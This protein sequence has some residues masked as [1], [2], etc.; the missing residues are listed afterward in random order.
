MSH[1]KTHASQRHGRASSSTRH[2]VTADTNSTSL[3]PVHQRPQRPRQAA[4]AGV[5]LTGR[6]LLSSNPRAQSR[7][8]IPPPWYNR[9]ASGSVRRLSVIPDQSEPSSPLSPVSQR[10]QRRSSASPLP[11]HRNDQV[12][13][14]PD[15]RL[16]SQP[17]PNPFDTPQGR[18]RGSHAGRYVKP[19]PSFVPDPDSASSSVPPSVPPKDERPS[20]YVTKKVRASDLEA[21]FGLGEYGAAAAHQR[22]TFPGKILA[23]PLQRAGESQQHAEWDSE[24]STPTASLNDY[25]TATTSSTAA[26]DTQL[27]PIQLVKPITAAERSGREAVGVNESSRSG[28]PTAVAPLP[29][30]AATA[31]FIQQTSAEGDRG[32]L[33]MHTVRLPNGRTIPTVRNDF[34]N[35]RRISV[36]KTSLPSD[37]AAQGPSDAAKANAAAQETIPGSHT[38]PRKAVPSHDSPSNQSEERRKEGPQPATER[39]R[40]HASQA[41]PLPASPHRLRPLMLSGDRTVSNDRASQM[42]SSPPQHSVHRS[43]PSLR[44]SRLV[45]A[46]EAG[47]TRQT[48]GPG[49]SLFEQ[50]SA[51]I[52]SNRVHDS[53]CTEVE[54]A[55]QG[56]AS[57][58]RPDEMRSPPSDALTE[59]Q[60]YALEARNR[61]A[62]S[63]LPFVANGSVTKAAAPSVNYRRPSISSEKTAIDEDGAGNK[64][65]ESIDGSLKKTNSRRRSSST[66]LGR[67]HRPFAS[68]LVAPPS[69]VQEASEPGTVVKERQGTEKVQENQPIPI[70]NRPPPGVTFPPA[71]LARP[72]T[73]GRPGTSGTLRSLMSFRSRTAHQRDGDICPHCFRAGFDCAL[74]LNIN[75][76]TAGRKTFQQ[77]VAGVLPDVEHSARAGRITPL[78]TSR[79]GTR[80][81]SRPVTRGSAA[82]GNF[83]H[84][85]SV[86]F[87]E[88]ALSR[89]V[90][91]GAVE[92]L[93]AERERTHVGLNE[94]LPYEDFMNRLQQIQ[95]QQ[96]DEKHHP[97]RSQWSISP[98]NRTIELDE[99]LGEGGERSPSGT[100]TPVPGS[101]PWRDPHQQH[102]HVM[103]SNMN[104]GCEVL[105]RNTGFSA[106]TAQSDLGDASIRSEGKF[107]MRTG[108]TFGFFGVLL[109]CVQILNSGLSG[110]MTGQTLDKPPNSTSAM[111]GRLAF[112]WGEV[113]GVFLG[114]CLYRFGTW[115]LVGNITLAGVFALVAGFSQTYWA[116]NVLRG[117]IGLCGGVIF[118]FSIGNLLDMLPSAHLRF[119][120]LLTLI[121]LVTVPQLV[122]PWV[123]QLFQIYINWRWLYWAAAIATACAVPILMLLAREPWINRVG[124]PNAVHDGRHGP[125]QGV[126]IFILPIS[127]LC[128]HPHLLLCSIPMAFALGILAMLLINIHS[129]WV[130]AYNFS[131]NQA[132]LTTTICSLLGLIAAIAWALITAAWRQDKPKRRL[133]LDE[134]GYIRVTPAKR[135]EQRLFKVAGGMLI[136]AIALFLL[137]ITTRSDMVHW[138]ASALLFAIMAG[139]III[140]AIGALQYPI[141]VYHPASALII[142]TSFD[143]LPNLQML[144]EE[145]HWGRQFTLS[146][147]AGMA[148][149]TLAT[150]GIMSFIA[151]DALRGVGFST[152]CV[153][154]A[155]CALFAG[156]ATVLLLRLGSVMRSNAWQRHNSSMRRAEEWRCNDRRQR[157]EE[158]L[159]LRDADVSP[160]HMQRQP[161]DPHATARQSVRDHPTLGTTAG[162][163]IG[164]SRAGPAQGRHST[165]KVPKRPP[166]FVLQPPRESDEIG[167]ARPHTPPGSFTSRLT[168]GTRPDSRINDVRR[169]LVRGRSHIS[170]MSERYPILPQISPT[171]RPALAGVNQSAASNHPVDPA[172]REA[173]MNTGSRLKNQA[174]DT[175]VDARI[176]SSIRVPQ[177]AATGHGPRY[178]SGTRRV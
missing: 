24:E 45:A 154:L 10:S 74:N 150:V 11:H 69:A 61:I 1:Y 123:A 125:G 50:A 160:S 55:V 43:P 132:A 131:D 87:G 84:L 112:F 26:R 171:D 142:A 89:P 105:R 58:H 9:D 102:Y 78:I 143:D 147:V 111:G 3:E 64:V 177:V 133:H 40:T 42:P 36:P 49:A 136:S 22:Q 134:N 30:A 115:I 65:K 63:G 80:G 174:N 7:Q 124:T 16:E 175:R 34:A 85:G 27:I 173:V 153:I 70:I 106:R 44:S 156:G 91:R 96:Q 79:P 97:E 170:H 107:T 93:L 54:T 158:G 19:A 75:G 103:Y 48:F 81:S 145:Q 56:N 53:Q 77:F 32:E 57:P 98:T 15:S 86:A 163:D 95:E 114:A 20:T 162:K 60:S 128:V 169:F 28:P 135:P 141:E 14:A 159:G 38:V 166:P 92:Q 68:E 5:P 151:T 17:L 146:A 12:G 37:V 148:G 120:G 46:G 88:S 110:P 47:P 144:T 172:W 168:R 108:L 2:S 31:T 165:S 71:V 13:S 99:K 129:L 72:N 21:G 94:K 176:E 164:H 29:R 82:G 101:P 139:G 104:P 51:Q 59:A 167:A 52:Q 122:G 137:G 117:M 73:R 83:A 149:L 130:S 39:A 25:P 6:Q 126:R 152:L 116:L 62:E 100:A 90:T 161:T 109:F 157:D 119:L 8:Q 41:P 113:V 140:T 138:S 127:L 4:E 67:D 18:R 121:V 33:S 118:L 178:N 155:C 66:E 35:M 76:G 23:T